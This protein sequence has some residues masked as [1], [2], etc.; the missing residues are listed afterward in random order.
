V[1]RI[2]VIAT[3]QIGDVLL[4]TPLISAARGRWPDARIE[5]LG[6]TGTLG[7]LR[8]NADVDGL[9]ESP[10]R[11]GWRG[12][13][14]FLARHWRRYD[15]ALVT[16]P[17]D[18]AHLIGWIASACR[19]GLIPENG[20]SNWWKQ[21]LLHHAVTVAGDR[22]NTH[23]VVEKL[24]LLEPWIRPGS[25]IPR[26]KP[27]ST[28]KIPDQLAFQLRSEFVVIHTPSM[29]TYKQWPLSHYR[30]LIAGLLQQGHQIVLTGGPGSHDRR[31]V[32]AMLDLGKPPALLNACG[33]LDFNQLAALLKSA[34]L[35]I[36]PDTSISH[37]A[38]ATGVDLLG[39]FGPTN[40]RRW[41]P[42]PAKPESKLLFER[43]ATMQQVGNVTLMQGDLPCVPC[44]RAGCEDHRLSESDCLVRQIKPEKVLDEAIRLLQGPLRGG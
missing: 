31:C 30:H 27:P 26:V 41:G 35:Y 37:L 15:L 2:L 14:V 8:G 23:V 44:G 16:Q 10:G 11:L 6:F 20:R 33:A 36:G 22:G 3:Q 21:R 28:Q 24:S 19:S 4:T 18:R 7:M 39:I 34:S 17:G 40:P 13:L 38:A 5:V 25:V 1:K 9:I 32:E 12:F 43:S 29:W 42:W